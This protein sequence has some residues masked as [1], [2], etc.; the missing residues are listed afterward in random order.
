[1][2]C[3]LQVITGLRLITVWLSHETH[4]LM[5]RYRA[6]RSEHDR[7]PGGAPTRAGR[8]AAASL[9]RTRCQP[10]QLSKRI[11]RRKR[12]QLKAHQMGLA[13]RPFLEHFVGPEVSSTA[14]ASMSTPS[15]PRSVTSTA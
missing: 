1:M 3:K 2:T 15:Q 9:G 12:D 13:Q 7:S 6:K 11:E 5:Q 4:H 10:L 8:S 14:A